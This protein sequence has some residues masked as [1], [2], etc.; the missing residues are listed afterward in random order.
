MLKYLQLP[1]QFDAILLQK[2]VALLSNELWK[3]HYQK[4]HYTGEWSAIPLR[5]TGGQID[6]IMI[7][8][9]NEVAYQDTIL[10]QSCP[11]IISVLSQ[12]KCP[13]QAVRLLKLSAGAVI[14]E[15]RDAE[16]NFE[17]GEI[18]IHIPVATHEDVEFILDNER[19]AL[20]EGS[21]WYMN[22]NLPHHIN[23]N[24][25]TDRIHLVI[26]ALVNDWVKELFSSADIILK[27]E[28]PD[29]ELYPEAVKRQMIASFREMNTPTSNEMADRMEAEL[30]NR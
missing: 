6:N 24:S 11:Y 7:S 3:A 4:M 2:E 30:G 12:F 16:L 23:N 19:M 22:F 1:F 15:H 5:S 27:K 13:L 29:A 26:D 25:N 18:R 21:C 28:V 20:K 17:K 10:L 8:P 9:T 14:K